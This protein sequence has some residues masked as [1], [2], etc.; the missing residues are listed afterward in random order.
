MSGNLAEHATTTRLRMRN[1][2]GTM[3]VFTGGVKSFPDGKILH[4]IVNLCIGRKRF[5]D[6]LTFT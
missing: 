6:L 3:G 5:T 1:V 4:K 2:G